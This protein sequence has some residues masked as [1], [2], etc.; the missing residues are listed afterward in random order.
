MPTARCEKS[1][2]TYSP[3]L[4]HEGWPFLVFVP[5]PV[6]MFGQF[7]LTFLY[8]CLLVIIAL[9]SDYTEFALIYAS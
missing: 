8:F 2:L 3:N 6:G 1:S 9:T 7:V 4:A 5:V